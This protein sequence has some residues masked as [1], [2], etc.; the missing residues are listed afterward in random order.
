MS[1]DTAPEV[2]VE[3]AE[4]VKGY[5][6]A[7]KRRIGELFL[8]CERNPY[9]GEPMGPGRH[10]ELAACRRMRMGRRWPTGRFANPREGGESQPLIEDDSGW[11]WVSSRSLLA[12][13][14]D[15]GKRWRKRSRYWT[16]LS[17]EPRPA[18]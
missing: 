4:G 18:G 1:G 12:R 2:R 9:V 16:P 6:E 8:E 3:L 13:V 17:R 11:K 15:R 5:V 14:R 10:P 7:L